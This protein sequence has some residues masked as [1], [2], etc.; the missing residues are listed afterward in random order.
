M[1][2][3]K[4]EK[5]GCSSF[6]CDKVVK[7]VVFE[8][9]VGRVALNMEDTARVDTAVLHIGGKYICCFDEEGLGGIVNS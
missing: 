2:E 4:R 3:S 5:E 1:G 6:D 7:P 8:W 9:V